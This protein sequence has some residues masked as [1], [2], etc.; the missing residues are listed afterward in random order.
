MRVICTFLCSLI[1]SCSTSQTVKENSL[2]ENCP[3][4]SSGLYRI[5]TLKRFVQNDLEWR[6][7]VDSTFKYNF[8]E[9]ADT[10]ISDDAGWFY[11]SKDSSRNHY[12]LISQGDY[13]T[14]L[15][16]VVV[17]K[18]NRIKHCFLGAASGGDGGDGFEIY[19]SLKGNVLK[20]T[21]VYTSIFMDSL[22]NDFTDSLQ[23]NRFFIEYLVKENGL[24]IL[25]SDSVSEVSNW[26]NN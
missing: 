9:C 5:E 24:E 18:K 20:Q 7:K 19:S 16:V 4:D 8:L 26:E 13:S 23:I 14:E 6:L 1:L 11:L 15:W 3:D 22:K 10:E 25:K 12:H 17:D 21:K 2:C